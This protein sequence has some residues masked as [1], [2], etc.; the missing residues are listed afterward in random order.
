MITCQSHDPT[1]PGQ[2]WEFI[3]HHSGNMKLQHLDVLLDNVRGGPIL[4]IPDQ[5]LVGLDNICKLVRQ[6]IL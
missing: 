4:L 2:A 5:L 6:V 1:H 3:V